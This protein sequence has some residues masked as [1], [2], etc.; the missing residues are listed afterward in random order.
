MHNSINL[1]VENSVY[2]DKNS[3]HFTR[4]L[5]DGPIGDFLPHIAYLAYM[6]TG[7]ALDVRTVWRK[8]I[9]DSPLPADEFRGLIKGE[10]ASG[11]VSFNGGAKIEGLWL[12]VVGTQMRV[13]ANLYEPPRLVRR[14]F[15]KGEPALMTLVDGISEFS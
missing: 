12:R 7:E 5:P 15:R 1:A 11:F 8:R 14:R 2:T 6:F 10:R 13:E 3:T 4:T 9:T